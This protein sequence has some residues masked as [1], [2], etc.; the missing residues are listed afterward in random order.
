MTAQQNSLAVG[1]RVHIVL[2]PSCRGRTFAYVVESGAPIRGP[3]P[4]HPDEDG[5][6]GRVIATPPYAAADGHHTIAVGFDV[7][8]RGR[9]TA[10]A[11]AAAGVGSDVR[12]E[13]IGGMFAPD[14]IV[15][16]RS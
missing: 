5:R 10:E 15:V 3:N 6:A 12:G 2:R 16:D 11:R 8:I 9:M 7:P 1:T 13:V 4:H 14:E